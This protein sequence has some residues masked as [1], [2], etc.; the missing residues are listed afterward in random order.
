MLFHHYGVHGCHRGPSSIAGFIRKRSG[1]SFIFRFRIPLTISI[2]DLN[3]KRRLLEIE[4]ELWQ[5]DTE[6][7]ESP[8]QRHDKLLSRRVSRYSILAAHH[9]LDTVRHLDGEESAAIH[10]L[11][12]ELVKGDPDVLHALVTD[13][14]DVIYQWRGQEIEAVRIGISFLLSVICEVSMQDVKA[15]AMSKLGSILSSH[16]SRHGSI[17]STSMPHFV[18]RPESFFNWSRG[19]VHPS[20]QLA[21]GELRLQGAVLSRLTQTN[22]KSVRNT[23]GGIIRG[24]HPLETWIRTLRLAGKECNVSNP[25]TPIIA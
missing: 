1:N 9:R 2:V 19:Y 3:D 14:K 16:N 17:E 5:K 20:P 13:F 10:D 4:S 25:I 18:T 24:V 7:A 12:R 11:V 15:V 23:Y 8:I 22:L 6:Y 21:D